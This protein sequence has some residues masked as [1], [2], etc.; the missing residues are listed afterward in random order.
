MPQ[1]CEQLLAEDFC[2]CPVSQAFTRRLI[3]LIAD[4]DKIR[5]AYGEGIDLSRKPFS[6]SPVGVLDRAFLP[7][8]LRVAEPSL[9]A[10]AGLQIKPV[11]KLSAAVERDRAAGELGQRLE[12]LHKTVHNW[13]RL[14]IIVAQEYREP[15]GS[16]DKRGHIGFPKL[17]PE[18]DQVTF[19]VTKL[20]AISNSIRAPQ[21]VQFRAKPLPVLASC[22]SWAS[23]SAMLWQV[24]PKLDCV[25]V[26]RVGELVDRFVT[27]RDWVPFQTHPASDLLGR[28]TVFD[29]VDDGLP[30]IREAT[31]FLSLARRS[32]ASSAAWLRTRPCR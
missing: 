6:R 1:L 8:R 21:D 20:L 31:N 9:R 22:M 2:R 24:T 5:V 27:D 15:A 25:S 17:L 12:R 26:G 4:R 11:C 29:P 30:D 23:S 28:P 14:P 19:P 7:G 13:P 32:Q 3:E 10:N 16:F 18:L